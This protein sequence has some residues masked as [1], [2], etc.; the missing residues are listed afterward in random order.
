M[1]Q[2]IN[3]I[4]LFLPLQ[5]CMF[6]ILIFYTVTLCPCGINHKI[7]VNLLTQSLDIISVCWSHTHTHSAKVLCLF[8]FKPEKKLNNVQMTFMKKCTIY[9]KC[10]KLFSPHSASEQTCRIIS[11]YSPLKKKLIPY[12]DIISIFFPLLCLIYF[13]YNFFLHFNESIYT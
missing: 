5:K 2:C 7:T 13:I 12:M 1:K 3:T 11:C 10:M 8:C 6:S 9:S 4:Y